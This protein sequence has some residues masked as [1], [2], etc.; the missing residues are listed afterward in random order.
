MLEVNSKVLVTRFS[1]LGDVAMLAVILPE[2]LEQNSK[3]EIHMMSRPGFQHVFPKHPRLHFIGADVD[4]E[5]KS[6]WGIRRLAQKLRKKKFTHYADCHN[7]LRTQILNRL[8]GIPKTAILDKGR[9]A[10]K[11]MTRKHKK[12]LSPLTSM[13]ER[14]AEVFRKLGFSVHLSHDL[15]QFEVNKSGI[16]IAPF[17]FYKEKM[18]PLD[19]TKEFVLRLASEG[20]EISLFGGGELEQQI[21]NEWEVLHENITSLA[22][23]FDLKE[24]LK[25]M[26]QLSLMV[27]MDSANMHLASLSGTRVI[28]VWGATHPYLGFLGYGQKLED[29][30]QN[31][32]LFCRPCSVY[33]NKECYRK[34]LECLECIETDALFQKVF[35]AYKNLENSIS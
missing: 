20:F 1:A 4:K 22:G 5:Y 26:Q 24:E 33:G 8:L 14:Y 16:G 10:K 30:V 23:K 25:V 28:S 32:E 34:N 7:V 15:P 19:K 9:N 31:I 35:N 6:V 13:H 12:I 18:Y 17:A 27:S 3:M 11:A 29:C 21:L 2:I